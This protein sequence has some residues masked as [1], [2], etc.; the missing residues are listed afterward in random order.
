MATTNSPLPDL[1]L[2]TRSLIAK[3]VTLLGLPQ[4][5]REDHKLT[6]EYRS[7]SVARAVARGYIDSQTRGKLPQRLQKKRRMKIQPV[8]APS[9][10]Q[11]MVFSRTTDGSTTITKSLHT[12]DETEPWGDSL[13]VKDDS[14]IRIVSKQIGGLGITVGNSK[15]RELK[16]W[17][18][19]NEIDCIGLQETNVFWKKCND[20]SQF[21]ERMR[22]HKWDFVR[23]STAFNKH[24]F[25]AFN[26]FGGAAIVTTNVV[27]SRVCCT[28]A[29]ETGLGRW[30]WVQYRGKNK[31]SARVIS[32][33][34]PHKP[35]DETLHPKS[36]YRQQQRYWMNKK[37]DMC[38]LT[39]FQDDLCML[40]Q[41]WIRNHERIVL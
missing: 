16:N 39:H 17:I 31:T 6:R 37:S 26:Q 3:V 32:V 18:I 33:Y 23:T 36:V 4:T 13:I 14:T 20:K 25:T 19:E 40:L 27:A 22:H 41:K 9:T 5:Q 38:P 15:E 7:S 2:V 29:D 21:R 10:M 34:Q 8:Q 28:G 24:E 12:D 35:A 1:A 11:Q 30:A